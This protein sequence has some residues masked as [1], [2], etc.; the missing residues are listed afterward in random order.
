MALTTVEI[1]TLIIAGWGA[2]LST[3]LAVIKIVENRQKLQVTLEYS[4][5]STNPDQMNLSIGSTN[6]GKR[7]VTING[8]GIRLPNKRNITI[9][10]NF[11]TELPVRLEDGDSLTIWDDAHSIA[12]LVSSKGY[13]KK[14]KIKGYVQDTTGKKYFSKKLD[15]DPQ[16]WIKGV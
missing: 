9:F 14:I 12:E 8:C 3:F 4:V 1:I 10:T 16:Q 13:Q 11:P 2:L 5:P 6:V 15:F 7:P